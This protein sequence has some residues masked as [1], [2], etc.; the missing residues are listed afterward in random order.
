LNF[1]SEKSQ[2]KFPK[3]QDWLKPFFFTPA[4]WPCL[5]LS[6][7]TSF[8]QLG[9]TTINVLSSGCHDQKDTSKAALPSTSLFHFRAQNPPTTGMW[10]C[11]RYFTYLLACG[12]Q[13]DTQTVWLFFLQLDIIPG[14]SVGS[15]VWMPLL[16]QRCSK[17]QPT[18]LGVLNAEQYKKVLM[19]AQLPDLIILLLPTYIHTFGPL[20]YYAPNGCVCN[21]Y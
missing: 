20:D 2:K 3:S 1:Y 17:H 11:Y 4:F 8:P 6:H 9:G 12:Y 15:S 14:M 18:W 10:T 7:P 16:W 21:G 5:K 13:L 19:P